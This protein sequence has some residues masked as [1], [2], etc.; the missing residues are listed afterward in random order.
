MIL[1][2]AWRNHSSSSLRKLLG[3][4]ENLPIS[5]SGENFTSGQK[6][7]TLCF[8]NVIY[9]CDKVQCCREVV[10]FCE[11]EVGEGIMCGLCYFIICV[12]MDA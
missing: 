9:S 10:C 1:V 3:T 8:L 7:L 5:E 11:S 6:L 4:V 2:A 12:E